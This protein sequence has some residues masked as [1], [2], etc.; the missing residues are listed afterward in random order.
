MLSSIGSLDLSTCQAFTPFKKLFKSRRLLPPSEG[1]FADDEDKDADLQSNH[2]RRDVAP[3]PLE[4]FDELVGS[5]EQLKWKMIARPGGATM[6]PD[7]YY[8]LHGEQSPFSPFFSFFNL[9]FFHPL[10]CDAFLAALS[11]GAKQQFEH[12][13]CNTG[14]QRCVA[15]ILLAF[16]CGSKE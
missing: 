3:M 9:A 4:R 13:D 12:G 10:F 2:Q 14:V 15:A 6:R 8:R 11:A 5:F 7:D 1:A 16:L